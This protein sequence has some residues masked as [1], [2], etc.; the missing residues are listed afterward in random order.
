MT[1]CLGE[2]RFVVCHSWYQPTDPA[3]GM[4]D[5]TDS[6]SLGF[7]DTATNTITMVPLDGFVDEIR[8]P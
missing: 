7:Y 5:E 4:D 6:A 1:P 3:D 8:I 2:S